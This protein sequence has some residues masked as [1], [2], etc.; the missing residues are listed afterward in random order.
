MSMCGYR[1]D[2]CKADGDNIIEKDD[3][4]A[5]EKVWHKLY[6]LTIEQKRGC[7]QSW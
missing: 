6:D 3:R 4:V 2:L 7:Y 5:I 1:C